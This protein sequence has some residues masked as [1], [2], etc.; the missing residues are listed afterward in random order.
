MTPR[1][2]RSALVIFALLLPSLLALW[3]S[4]QLASTL[5]RP[6]ALRAF[7]AGGQPFVGFF[8][9]DA[10]HLL[11]AHG[12]TVARQPIAAL[13]L[14][15]EPT[16]FD[17]TVD[18]SGRQQAWLFDDSKPRVVR[19]DVQPAPLQLTGC[20]QA[21]AGPQ[22]KVQRL[23]GA[24]HIAVDAAR[25]RIYVADA[26]GSGVR[27]LDL[28]GRPLAA[29]PEGL[30]FFPNRLRLQG[31]R[32]LVADNDH[33]RLAWLDVAGARP[34]LALRE[35]L[36]VPRKAADFAL[37]PGD[38]GLWV[39]SVGQ[40]QKNGRILRYGRDHGMQGEAD[41]GGFAD[42]L[43]IERFGDALLVADF[44]GLALYRIDGNGR[45]L[46]AFG[47]GGI[48]QELEAARRQRD[49]ARTWKLAAWGGL[50]LTMLVGS[51]LAWRFSERPLRPLPAAVDATPDA[52]A[53]FELLPGRWFVQRLL[54]AQA[55]VLLLLFA[56]VA[57]GIA[58]RWNQIPAA[59]RWWMGA[60]ALFALAVSLGGSWTT[61]RFGQ[62]SLRVEKGR[63]SLWRQGRQRVQ[64][65]L[66]AL[67][68]S[69]RSLLIGTEL[70]PYRSAGFAGRPGRWVYDEEVLSNQLL[71]GLPPAQRVSEAE[72]KRERMRRLPRWQW[73]ALVLPM[74]AALAYS[75]WVVLR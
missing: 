26:K 24:V 12:T 45:H 42:P 50:V 59:S 53:S 22:L 25:G 34:G 3:W 46:G 51:V 33:H 16:D 57:L 68:A 13:A 69:P 37:R 65:G 60:L 19:C 48:A 23:Q 28:E 21:M 39:L 11:D 30:L 47:S 49:A 73:A 9:H 67:L 35:Q 66:G 10:L 41:L 61:W 7:A 56:T 72:L 6:G 1:E 44:D 54:V 64:A 4:T 15:E 55:I 38:E 8:F 14:D 20:V 62:Q 74:V 40:G 5:P 17:V 18:A 70:V 43:V 63:I 31:D 29:T 32:L 75:V 52:T 58:P 71:A 2:R 27:V 36:A